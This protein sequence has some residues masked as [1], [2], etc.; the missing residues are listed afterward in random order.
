MQKTKVLLV[1]VRGFG[2]KIADAI[3]KT[4]N[5][6]LSACFHPQKEVADEYSEKYNCKSFTDFEEAILS[7]EIQAVALVTPNHLHYEQIKACLKAGKHIFVEKP[8][9]NSVNEAEDVVHEMEEKNL[10]LMVGHNM[11][12]NGAIRAMKRL[13]DEGRIGEIVSG[14]IN[15]SHAGGM[16]LT[17]DKWR[18]YKDKCPGGPLMMLGTHSVEISNYLFGP[19]KNAKGILKKLHAPTEAED[20]SAMLLDLEGGGYCYVANNYNHPGTHFIRAYG[21]KGILEFNRNIGTLTLQGEDIDKNPAELENIPFEKNDML[22]EEME[23]W[24]ECIQTGEKPET[25]GKE[26]IEALKIVSLVLTL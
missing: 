16:K 8:I 13:I 23:E 25:G 7:P 24:G 12:R 5:L 11:R 1:G 15:M 22:L 3:L 10:T 6:E 18:Y 14:E 21:T 26:A 19:T 4:S 9:T 17:S 2:E 20:T